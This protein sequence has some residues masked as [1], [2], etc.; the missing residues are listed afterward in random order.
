MKLKLAL[1]LMALVTSSALVASTPAQEPATR[2]GRTIFATTA[3]PEA[4]Q[5]APVPPPPPVVTTTVNSSGFYQV[6]PDVARPLVARWSVAPED[7]NLAREADQLARA[8]G[9]AK[10]DTERDKIKTQLGELLKQQFDQRQKRHER[11]IADLEAQVKK[12]KDLVA[13][14]QENRR[15][16]IAQRLDQIVRESQ[17]LGW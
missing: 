11:E 13:K 5:P 12:L 14:R 10:S 6:G 1:V 15:E 4:P 16:I 9:E 3:P 7:A 17:G 2:V 8:L